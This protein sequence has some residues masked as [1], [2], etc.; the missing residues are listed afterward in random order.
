VALLEEAIKSRLT[1][2]AGLTA[3]IGTRAYPTRMPQNPVYPNLV[4]TEIS[5]I[6]DYVMGGQSG[7]ARARYQI[8]CYADSVS[9]VKALAEQVRL[10]LSG[11]RGTV[12]AVVID[13]VL[14]QNSTTVDEENRVIADYFFFYREAIP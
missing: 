5:N 3:L 13:L 10:A 8:D 14:K 7:I 4:F 12:A 11:F 1:T 6:P 2:F 9:G